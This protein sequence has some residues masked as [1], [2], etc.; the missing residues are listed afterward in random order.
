MCGE[1]H[2]GMTK[3]VSSVK[4]FYLSFSPV[5]FT[6]FFRSKCK[7]EERNGRSDEE[8]L[9]EKLNEIKAA[10]PQAVC[11]LEIDAT[12]GHL[13]FLLIQ[14]SEMRL[15]LDKFPEVVLMDITYKINKNKMPVS[16]IEVMNGEGN[17]DVVAYAFLANEQKVTLAA[18]LEAFMESSGGREKFKQTECVLVDK[19]FSEIGAIH[20]VMPNAAIHICSVHV[21]KNFKE[22]VKGRVTQRRLKFWMS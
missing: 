12:T 7:K 8:M 19:D 18:M 4:I 14:T 22:L 20:E 21:E 3:L 9:V 13:L 17:G 11:H 10:D 6:F 1:L 16:V 5:L 15:A 2:H